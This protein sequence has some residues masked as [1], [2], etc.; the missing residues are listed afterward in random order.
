MSKISCKILSAFMAIL[1]LVG[2]IPASA[3]TTFA[4][5][6]NEA[7]VEAQ[8]VVTTEKITEV[9]SVEFAVADDINV[10]SGDEAD[11]FLAAGDVT[12]TVKVNSPLY[13]S[14][15]YSTAS[16]DE[17]DYRFAVIVTKV[18]DEGT[19]ITEYRPEGLASA[20][21]Y[22]VAGT[23][24]TE[25]KEFKW[26]NNTAKLVFSGDA[27]Y[28]LKY[29]HEEYTA[30]DASV[31]TASNNVE[32]KTKFVID[33]KAPE[34]TLTASAATS[35][36]EV[37]ITLT[38]IDKHFSKAG[39][40]FDFERTDLF[41]NVRSTEALY[42]Q[43]NGEWVDNK[44]TIKANEEGIYTAKATVADILGNTSSEKS[45]DFIIDTD[46]P[47]VEVEYTSEVTFIDNF[48]EKF[49]FGFSNA[50]IKAKVIVSDYISN[51]KNVI[52][53]V[54]NADGTVSTVD[55]VVTEET[56]VVEKTFSIPD[57]KFEGEYICNIFNGYE[58][59]AYDTFGHEGVFVEDKII[60]V[61]N[62]AP[63][64]SLSYGGEYDAQGDTVYS[65][66]VL[67]PVITVK[68]KNFDAD[69]VTVE[70]DG[71]TLDL[72][73]VATDDECYT[74]TLD[75]FG[76][77]ESGACEYNLSI[78]CTDRVGN[79]FVFENTDENIL[80][81]EGNIKPVVVTNYNTTL[82]VKTVEKVDKKNG[83]VENA[84]IEVAVKEH[85]LF[86]FS[87]DKVTV[88][89]NGEAVAD[90]KWAQ[91]GDLYT[92]VFDY[93][94][95]GEHKVEAMYTTYDGEELT[96]S[97][98]VKI[99]NTAPVI[100]STV[101]TPESTNK[102]LKSIT[103][104]V[105]NT[106][107][108]VEVEV[109]DNYSGIDTFTYSDSL[110]CTGSEAIENGKKYTFVLPEEDV[111]DVSTLIENFELTAFDKAGNKTSA[112]TLGEE[113]FGSILIDN[114]TPDISVTY[115]AQ[116]GVEAT[117]YNG[118]IYYNSTD[119]NCLI[120]VSDEFFEL[121]N[122]VVNSVH[123]NFKGDK[124]TPLVF[125]E[126]SWAKTENNTYACE[127]SFDVLPSDGV[128]SIEIK[129][130]DIAGNEAK[131]TSKEVVVDTAAPVI[132][133]Y[134]GGKDEN[135]ATDKAPASDAEINYYNKYD[136][137]FI[138]ITD[139]S[140]Q[141]EDIFKSS[142]SSLCNIKNINNVTL[143]GV[144]L[145]DGWKKVN[146]TTYRAQLAASQL[147][148]GVYNF[149]ISCAD[150][151][152]N[153]ASNKETF[154]IDESAPELS[155]TYS[156]RI[157]GED[158]VIDNVNYSFYDAP[159][160]VTVTAK[161]TDSGVN[162]IKIPNAELLGSDTIGGFANNDD[163]TIV[164][165]EDLVSSYTHTAFEIPAA[166]V[167]SFSQLLEG[168]VISATNNAYVDKDSDNTITSDL[169]YFKDSENKTN[170]AIIID[171]VAPVIT[172]NSITGTNK[173]EKDDLIYFSHDS[174]NPVKAEFTVADD[175]FFKATDNVTVTINGEV[176]EDV[177]WTDIN[178]E[179]GTFTV[180]LPNEGGTYNLKVEAVDYSGNVAEVYEQTIIIASTPVKF[181]LY[182]Q[183]GDNETESVMNGADPIRSTDKYNLTF[184]FTDINFFEENVTIKINDEVV[185]GL[186]WEKEQGIANSYSASYVLEGE[187]VYKVDVEYVDYSAKN[188]YTHN[189]VFTL[190][191]TLPVID[192][193]FTPADSSNNVSISKSNAINEYINKYY[194]NQD[195]TVTVVV[196]DDNSGVDYITI[197]DINFTGK[198]SD[199]APVKVS[200]DPNSSDWYI[201]EE[202]GKLCYQFEVLGKN[203][204]EFSY[205]D[206][207]VTDKAENQASAKSDIHKIIVDSN[208]PYVTVEYQ[209]DSNAAFV[210]A[211]GNILKGD[212]ENPVQFMDENVDRVYFS[213]KVTPVVTVEEAFFE[214]RTDGKDKDGKVTAF[215]TVVF[216]QHFTDEDGNKREQIFAYDTPTGDDPYV[217]NLPSFMTAD[218][219]Y[220]LEIIC[221]DLAG[222]K[223][224]I[225]A[226]D[227]DGELVASDRNYISKTMTL[228]R[229][230][231]K[232]KVAETPTGVI[233]KAQDVK[234]DFTERN[235][236][237]DHANISVT[238]VDVD[239][240]EVSVNPT[241]TWSQKGHVH[242]A[243]ISF[244]DDAVY[245]VRA[246]YADYVNR[247]EK[248]VASDKCGFTLDTTA[249]QNLDIKCTTKLVD[250]IL[251]VLTFGFFKE[252]VTV[253]AS[254]V[255]K[256]SGVDYFTFNYIRENGV[257]AINKGN[258]TEVKYNPARNE[259]VYTS[260]FVIKAQA[261]GRIVVNAVDFAGNYFDSEKGE[262]VVAGKEYESSIIVDDKNPEFSINLGTP[263]N[264][265]NNV[266]YYD[267]NFNAVITINEANFDSNAV[268][269]TVTRDGAS[270]PV[271]AKWDDSNTDVHTGTVTLSEDGD[272]IISV[273]YSD[274]SENMMVNSNGTAFTDQ[275]GNVT[276]VY[277]SGQLTIDTE[278]PTINVESVANESANNAETIGFK[279]TVTDVNID[280]SD[281]E[282]KFTA[283]TMSDLGVYHVDTDV[284]LGEPTVS[285]NS[286]IWEITNIDKDGYYEFS[287]SATDKA[288]HTVTQ[289]TL[290]D[291][292]GNSEDLEE[293]NFSANR[294][295]SAYKVEAMSL[296]T[297]S[298]VVINNELNGKY[299]KDDVK[300]V[301]TEFN[302]DEVNLGQQK[303][304]V[305]INDGASVKNVEL[306]AKN[307]KLDPPS[308]NPDGTIKRY[309]AT[310]TLDNSY[311]S[312][313]GK[314]SINVLSYDRAGNT[315]INTSFENS[316]LEF[317][318]DRT[319]PVIVANVAS[320]KGYNANKY[321]VEFMITDANLEADKVVAEILQ[322]GKVIASTKDGK[323]KALGNNEYSFTVDT[324][325]GYTLVVNAEDKAENKAEE[326][327]VENFTVTTN[328][329]VL[330]WANKPLFWG[331]TGGTLLVGA[332]IV[333]L[334][335]F[336]KKKK[337]EQ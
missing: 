43:A 98:T 246:S 31:K 176:A 32:G 120:E 155:V 315:N 96:A 233:N 126:E 33:T 102:V 20:D 196:S 281:I 163:Y 297:G 230:P 247:S 42:N 164:E 105:F 19:V 165:L 132:N 112:N 90:A 298:D 213:G 272:Y 240:K 210:D 158:I 180:T 128:L 235:F 34:V 237:V 278:S 65:K 200:Y 13:F 121:N 224:T 319:I 310:Y 50:P 309:T 70:L 23:G 188:L 229:Q 173:R 156:Q 108:N 287:C 54:I 94:S 302:I 306:N 103:N 78:S 317:T 201:R 15:D 10:A 227:L 51:I 186:V 138:E 191:K 144:N 324:G 208:N 220:Q 18:T 286:I 325:S 250:K 199:Y 17:K 293:M 337:N 3:L 14:K 187:G 282:N 154:V 259:Y 114:I 211:E 217:I 207:T 299:T 284:N 212:E 295:G 288:N 226:D 257:S 216:V 301:I 218:G 267:S 6:G 48:I 253:T 239:G 150:A 88:K 21:E 172:E 231:A 25:I 178:N 109:T 56:N 53:P 143:F 175:F 63:V 209:Y 84:K 166:E 264:T 29:F 160:T 136:D 228:D 149:D 270:Y 256:T 336:K 89:V 222:N 236:N 91:N 83:Y 71:E 2:M 101:K 41:G 273:K 177:K 265:E 280:A 1:M 335:V 162:Y 296:E 307:Y 68:E 95:D 110:N 318:V 168:F 161:D 313:D 4:E 283:Y 221:V 117:E 275:A 327:R 261:R 266:S 292:Q 28:S 5:T 130:V 39:V 285:G 38:A 87:A 123:K 305:S 321:D 74:A 93:K 189:T 323:I 249:P 329:L 255:E 73:W 312:N 67:T 311:F 104:G 219:D 171:N 251:S 238:G 47:T 326:F 331:V 60:V 139:D 203:N 148:D 129:C 157:N 107:V 184:N 197:P 80:D 182:G 289:F 248:Q 153:S 59:K 135:P 75:E 119:V 124:V 304:V 116:E 333:L 100:K 27:E 252:E 291:T 57:A 214:Y 97:E 225:T 152:A 37:V 243:T 81:A 79:G 16:P 245:T 277:T 125:T 204:V 36:E 85:E 55:E 113:G 254:A 169:T 146:G 76:F 185:N 127:F 145:K 22:V 202:D 193:E 181:L 141:F 151:A 111:T 262:G 328:K 8:K 118:R 263:V 77:G 40:T 61:D 133:I 241:I 179:S 147:V 279:V 303:T 45:V 332:G 72:N 244:K 9:T 11:T 86:G 92:L 190:D 330:F 294:E 290:T 52:L 194:W 35:D 82:T 183:Y 131:Y 142:V 159:V 46:G 140:Y 44:L 308:E 64:V 99:D 223:G 271:E 300:I 24:A 174:K 7:A 115:T 12:A 334:I 268:E 274:Y 66:N 198:A 322:G 137:V 62:V 58:I 26:N 276:D 167:D 192:V 195:L 49:T 260:T 232:V 134:Y 69:R 314:Y 215:N 206:F 30:E 242:T 170:N 205:A 106:L 234:I 258:I 316:I 320:N 122:I 269:I